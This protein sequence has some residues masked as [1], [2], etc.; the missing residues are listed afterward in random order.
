MTDV[1]QQQPQQAQGD[2]AGDR[3]DGQIYVYTNAITLAVDVAV[4]TG[5]PLLVSGPT[6]IGKSSLARKEALGRGWRYYEKTITSLT[7]ARDLLWE[8]DHL[9][10]L[11]DAHAQRIDP[12]FTTYTRPGVLWWAM[13]RDSAKTQAEIYGSA[14]RDPNIGAEHER[15][16]V[17]LDEIDKADP[18]VPNNLLVPLGSFHFLIDESGRTVTLDPKNKP[19][20]IIT[21]NGER[22]LPAAFLR[23]CVELHIPPADETRLLDIAAAHF[24]KERAELSAMLDVIKKARPAGF[25]EDALPSPAEFIDTIRAIDA[26]PDK[27]QETIA[28]LIVW[29]QS[30]SAKVV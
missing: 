24:K 5:R 18:D 28:G 30:Q 7:Q 16:V 13:N 1:P 22:E 19:L 20:I 6:G 25:A 8:I 2:S 11:N 26:L 23:R 17:L 9:R 15:A 12:D 3:S 4:A 27:S 29:K 14:A 10:R 21:T